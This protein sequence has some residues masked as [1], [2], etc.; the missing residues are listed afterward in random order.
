MATTISEHLRREQFDETE[1]A[2]F[3]I[4]GADDWNENISADRV[5]NRSRVPRHQQAM[6]LFDGEPD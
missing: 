5:R 3:Y 4:P 1:P 2:S 6:N